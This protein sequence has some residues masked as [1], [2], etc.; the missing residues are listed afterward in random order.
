VSDAVITRLDHGQIPRCKRVQRRKSRDGIGRGDRS[1]ADHGQ[2]R[3][4]RACVR[5]RE[6]Q[7]RVVVCC[8]RVRGH[9]RHGTDVGYETRASCR[10]GFTASARELF[11]KLAE[12]RMSSRSTSMS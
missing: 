9:T 6:G 2:V 5:G 4:A 3:L 8:S 1:H 7:G 10:L 12:Q 11:C